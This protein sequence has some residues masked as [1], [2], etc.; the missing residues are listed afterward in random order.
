MVGVI[1]ASVTLI[2]IAYQAYFYYRKKARKKISG[3]F[4]VS[5]HTILK[6]E[7]DFYDNLTPADQLVF[8]ERVQAFLSSVTITPV[9]TEI[10]DSHRLLVAAAALIPLFHLGESTYPNLEE[11][12]IYPNAFSKNHELQ[13]KNRNVA[14]M[15]GTGYMNG[16]MILSKRAL[17][18]GF[19]RA[20]DGQN[21]A[22]HEFVHLIDGW[23]G[24]IDGLPEVLLKQ[25]AVSPWLELIR[26]KMNEIKHKKSDI[27]S[28]GG[29]SATEFFPVA[30]E[31]FF[32]APDRM[33]K[34]HPELYAH[35]GDMFH[36]S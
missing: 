35:F 23:D 29:T 1:I 8:Q 30:A 22:I 18:G 3:P 20:K 13:G 31:Y 15:V 6:E 2:F 12:L 21:T 36:P 32:E 16:T 11:V 34:E 17:K 24:A 5:W 25:P 28:Y 26:I 27:D 33:K 14:G 10:D 7:V 9:Q 4:P 19:R